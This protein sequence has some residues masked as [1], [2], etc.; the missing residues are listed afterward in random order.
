MLRKDDNGPVV[1]ALSPPAVY[2]LSSQ[3]DWT[4]SLMYLVVRTGPDPR[5]LV[6]SLRRT[7]AE[8]DAGV[9]IREAATFDEWMGLTSAA[10]R[11]YAVVLAVFSLV[12]LALAAVGIYGVLAQSV[13]QRVHEI[14]VRMALGAGSRDIAWLVLSRTMAVVALGGVIGLVTAATAMR[15]LRAFLFEVSPADP[16]TL[17]VVAT[18]V[19]LVAACASYVPTRRATRA[20]PMTALRRE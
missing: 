18:L 2:V 13:G 1:S 15:T 20:D 4:G 10:P 16:L 11:F 5:T 12:A 9:S 17:A 7:V 6:P 19:L 8:L 14:G 3:S